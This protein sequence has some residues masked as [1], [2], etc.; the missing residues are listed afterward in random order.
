MP[1]VKK[2]IPILGHPTEVSEVP[3]VSQTEPAWAEITLEDGSVIKVKNVPTSVLRLEG[4]KNPM[5]G[6]PIY[7]VISTPVTVTVSAKGIRSEKTQ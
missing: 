2:M 1:E 4:Q 6:S 5:D 3:I 7:L